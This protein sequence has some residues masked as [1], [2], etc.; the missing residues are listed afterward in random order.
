MGLDTVELVME[1]EDAFSIDIPDAEAERLSTVGDVVDW[2]S[3][4][5]ER[6]GRPA[7]RADVT[8]RVIDLT[9]KKSGIPPDK[10]ALHMRFV[11]DLGLD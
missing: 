8:A 6:R 7:E 3:A 1:F 4:E 9:S 5:L 11:N 2:I 10:I